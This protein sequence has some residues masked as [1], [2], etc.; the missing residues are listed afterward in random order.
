MSRNKHHAKM[1]EMLKNHSFLPQGKVPSTQNS[2]S[3]CQ[4]LERVNL[5][6]ARQLT[7][8]ETALETE[9]HK[10][11]ELT[12]KLSKLSVCNLTEN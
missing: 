8:A 4:L 5:E 9:C 10:T 1:K 2:E 12:A 6:L 3:A 7:S 11:E